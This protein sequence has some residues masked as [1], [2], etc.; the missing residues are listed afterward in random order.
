MTRVQNAKLLELIG[1]SVLLC[2]FVVQNYLYD[3][4]AG[5][6]SKLDSALV[7][8]AIVDKS[9]LLNEAPP[10]GECA[11]GVPSRE[12]RR[13]VSICLSAASKGPSP[14]FPWPRRW[15]VGI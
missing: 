14:V 12:C 15:E 10:K 9:I 1:S 3:K 6:A 13:T 11:Q 2:S 7:Q 8:R 5:T 4:W